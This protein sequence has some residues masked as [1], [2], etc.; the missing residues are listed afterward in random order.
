M[1]Q[2]G[3]RGRT[4]RRYGGPSG[5]RGRAPIRG[6]D[7]RYERP[8]DG[9]RRQTT[10]RQAIAEGP[11]DPRI[12]RKCGERVLDMRYHLE[13]VHPRGGRGR[14]DKPRVD[15]RTEQ[16]LRETSALLEEARE[17]VFKEP[18]GAIARIE[19]A[20][21][22][23][24]FLTGASGPRPEGTGTSASVKPAAPA[25]TSSVGQ[26]ADSASTR[27]RR[28]F[29]TSELRR[30]KAGSPEVGGEPDES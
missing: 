23:L 19:R 28:H 1:K 2:R 21:E 14:D 3:G 24:S 29:M 18:L 5:G 16:R 9:D 15:P 6:G 30:P 4:D 22:A 20:Q 13:R 17:L 10:D 26:H 25:A 12:C 11:T 8:G 7:R 27:P